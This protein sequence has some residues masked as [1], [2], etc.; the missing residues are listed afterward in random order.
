MTRRLSIF[1]LVYL[2]TVSPSLAQAPCVLDSKETDGFRLYP[3]QSFEVNGSAIRR[4]RLDASPK[5]TLDRQSAQ[6]VKDR[7]KKNAQL[8]RPQR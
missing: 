8:R 6:W 2:L 5:W 1:V 7:V 3:S 4:L